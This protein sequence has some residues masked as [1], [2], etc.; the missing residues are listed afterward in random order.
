MKLSGGCVCGQ[1]R[2]ELKD[3]PLFVHA[4]HC[5]DC[6]RATGSAF[7]VNLGVASSDFVIEGKT[8]TVTNPTP[9]GSGYDAHFCPNCAT[10]LWSKY[11]FIDLPILALR[12]GTLDDPNLAP[13][14]YHVHTRRKQSWVVLPND[15]QIFDEW[16][17]PAEVW[18]KEALT[19]IENMVGGN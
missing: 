18:S 17:E 7:V 6:Q 14:T 1:V 12:G 13:P 5:S 2:Y 3:G 11:H 10:V 8:S 16:F 19:K 15:T 4:C 9:S